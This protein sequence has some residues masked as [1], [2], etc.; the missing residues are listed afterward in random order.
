V[1]DDWV[2]QQEAEEEERRR[3]EQEALDA[4]LQESERHLAEQQ[5]AYEQQAAQIQ[6][7]Y[8]LPRTLAE[9]GRWSPPD[10]EFTME[11]QGQQYPIVAE[12]GGYSGTPADI[13]EPE[14]DAFGPQL[15]A[16]IPM[17][18]TQRQELED[19]AREAALRNNI[20]P[21]LFVR[22]IGQESNW[23]PSAESPAG[24]YGIAQIVPRF[25]PGVN[26]RDP[27][28]SLDYA[29]GLMRRHLDT[30]GGDYR[31]ALA[32][33]NGGH[34]AVQQ[35]RA[36]RPYQETQLYLSRILGNESPRAPVAGPPV[37]DDYVP[38]EPEPL[39]PQREIQER[40]AIPSVNP[41][42]TVGNPDLVP[43]Q[44]GD[45]ALTAAEASAACGPAAAV[46]FARAM[47]RNPTLRE[48]LDL[49]RQSGWTAAGGMNGVANQQ[50]LLNSMGIPNRLETRLD[51]GRIQQDIQGGNPVTIS[52][53]NHYFVA[54]AYNPQTGQYH[55]GNSGTV[56]R[57]GAAW[58]TMAQIRQLG[59]G[60]NGVLYLDNPA[61][62]IPSVATTPADLADMEEGQRFDPSVVAGPIPEIPQMTGPQAAEEYLAGAQ[63]LLGDALG[64]AASAVGEGFWQLGSVPVG[65]TNLR[66]VAGAAAGPLQGMIRAGLAEDVIA[67]ETRELYTQMVA[68]VQQ[69]DAEGRDPAA[70]PAIVDLVDRYVMAA[71]QARGDDTGF[72]AAERHP[73]F[74]AAELIGGAATAGLGLAVAPNAAAGMARNLAGLAIDPTNAVGL[75][76]EGVTAGAR[77]LGSLARGGTTFEDVAEA[78]RPAA[79]FR[80]GPELPGGM[81]QLESGLI[82]PV[83]LPTTAV[84]EASAVPARPLIQSLD[85]ENA[86]LRGLPP[87]VRQQYPHLTRA[88]FS[89]DLA[90]ALMRI[91]EEHGPAFDDA[92]QR[93]QALDTTASRAEALG[94]TAPEFSRSPARTWSDAELAA[95]QVAR[96]QTAAG[97]TR[98]AQRIGDPANIAHLPIAE[99]AE[100]YLAL[101]DTVRLQLAARQTSGPTM[102]R[103]QA[104]REELGRALAQ[105]GADG[106]P[107]AGRLTATMARLGVTDDLLKNFVDVAQQDSPEA[108]RQFLR[109]LSDPGWW[110]RL[111]TLRF[112]SMLSGIAT[113]TNQALGNLL[114]LGQSVAV[115]PLAAAFDVG[116]ARA[117]AARGWPTERTRYAADA[118]AELQGDLLA[119]A[120]GWARARSALRTGY[121]PSDARLDQPLRGFGAAQA[122]IGPWQIGRPGPVASAVDVAMELPLRIFLASDELARGIAEGGSAHVLAT[123]KARR[124]GAADVGA[125]TQEILDNLV[126][127]RDVLTE[128]ED[129]ASRIVM[130]EG[131]PEITKLLDATQKVPLRLW[132]IAGPRFIR[133]PYN[134]AAQGLALSPAGYLQVLKLAREA[135]ELARAATLT[136]DQ[137]KRAEK[138]GA[139]L[140]ARGEMADAAAR[141]T[142]GTAVMATAHT[143]YQNDILTGPAPKQP[144]EEPPGWQPWSM[145][146]GDTYVSMVSLGPLAVPSVMGALLGHMINTGRL[147]DATE[148]GRFITD[149]TFLRGTAAVVEAFANPD[150]RWESYTEGLAGQL[151]PHGGL[152]NSIQQILGW[153]PR[154]PAGALEAMAAR[155]LPTAQTVPPRR[156]ILGREDASRVPG[157]GALSPLRMTQEQDTPSLQ[158]LR[159]LGITLGR[160]SQTVGGQRLTRSQYAQYVVIAGRNVDQDIADLMRSPAYRSAPPATQRATLG[161]VVQAARRRARE[162]LKLDRRQGTGAPIQWVGR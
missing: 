114:G 126:D 104:Q 52:T 77:A 103:L 60:V 111:E 86:Y 131:R 139:A 106:L 99:K 82:V 78:L 8:E 81:R 53:P 76:A 25:H 35:M 40:G 27:Y 144:S 10:P 69:A 97:A 161:R 115:R 160:P 44:F 110:Q 50:R 16:D 65:P 102:P 119:L 64:G 3:Q 149:S 91:A 158:E 49:A 129:M 147:R 98:W 148:L 55:V 51:E 117:G 128:A 12:I 28:A 54:D 75:A 41:P 7:L 14:H 48:A 85:A 133:T 22:Q 151:V 68:A 96:E 63:R 105:V 94:M 89:T 124:E 101:V 73:A 157:I 130:Q 132:Q 67:D 136:T 113:H 4:Q 143:L 42:G 15:P 155:F 17:P 62:P 1:F 31:T 9:Q 92:L 80:S 120:N 159:R 141:A 140:A 46:A 152:Q 153:A 109:G 150:R 112:G 32:A 83:D 58:M 33:Y 38:P 93:V 2:A 108:T 20:D 36:G 30:Y 137:A 34:G 37:P 135:D 71:T 145:R 134:I 142:I 87:E 21:D 5:A 95:Y 66:E 23:N 122:R 45:R 26:V 156:D 70:D 18:R 88:P 57:Q 138:V 118:G 13:G 61:S 24:A 72:R 84:P 154:N 121:S 47:G 11:Y 19:Y 146:L 107:D 100:A 39:P 125:R 127:H 6:S 74:G 116:F 90:G 79:P 59:N 29:A 56:Y 162:Q 43:N 123:R